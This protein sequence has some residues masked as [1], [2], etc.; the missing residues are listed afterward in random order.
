MTIVKN[1][2]ETT[3]FYLPKG[4]IT[5]GTM[6]GWPKK[7]PNEITTI[8]YTFPDHNTYREI[9]KNKNPLTENMR[10]KTLKD[11]YEYYRLV[12][13]REQKKQELNTIENKDSEASKKRTKELEEGIKK[14][15]NDIY[16][17]LDNIPIYI[18]S[19]QETIFPHQQE[20]IEEILKHASD[21]LPIFFKKISPYSNADLKF[22]YYNQFVNISGTKFISGYRKGSASH[23]NE[24]GTPIKEIKPDEEHDKPGTIFIDF[25]SREYY[26]TIKQDNIDEYIE[27]EADIYDIYYINK[28]KTITIARGN[29]EL[30]EEYQQN[31]HK[32]GSFVYHAFIHEL[33]HSLGLFHIWEYIPNEKH[34]VLDSL[35]YSVMSY[36]CPDI[37]DADFGG[38]YPMTF[39]LVDILLLQYLYG[40]NMTTR[41][42]NNTYGFHS[43]T[44]RAAYSLKSIEDKLVS[45]IWDSG[46]IDTLDF[47]LYTVNQ[48]INLNEGCFSDIGGL[49]SNIS[50]AYKTIIENAI[51]GKGDDTLI[52]NPFDNNLIGGDGNDLFYGGDG[53]DLFYGGSGNDV[54]YGEMGNDV[55]Y[56][57]DGDDMLI[58]YYGANMLNGGKGND[59]ICAAS[60]DRGLS[61]RNIIQGGEGDD[62]IYL[63]TGT[64]NVTGGQGNDTFNFFCYEGIESNS[65]I[66]DFEKNKD[67]ITLITR[68]YRKIDIT[69]MKKVDK[70]SGD[71]NEFSLNHNKPSNK[72]IIDVSTSSNDDKSIVHIEI[73]GIFNHDELFA[74]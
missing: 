66:W 56:G 46:G 38:L 20:V 50:I 58:D 8:T 17:I 51:G 63:G 44:G 48:V 36:K 5:T 37:K 60:T 19:T 31:K 16:T 25:S 71:K 2:K 32:I 54:I 13:I 34:K 42:E 47:S 7:S 1:V 43:N 62:E 45:C 30:R 14:I 59:R 69:K 33:G 6:I 21:I 49:R 70:L 11:I 68:D 10:K 29:N 4:I 15:A 55:L 72:T 73:V 67:K 39:M 23:P 35:K 12:N 27:N 64:H 74:V 41:L 40:P 26:K 52:G 61:G 22:G 28:N 57:D 9:I 24:E 65:S 3:N 53:N 18:Y